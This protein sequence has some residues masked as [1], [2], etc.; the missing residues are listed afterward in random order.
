MTKLIEARLTVPEAAFVVGLPSKTINREIDARIISAS[1]A[2]RR[3]RGSDLFYL[4]AIKDVRNQVGPGLRKSLR[5]AISAAAATGQKEA[6]C[7]HFVFAMDDLRKELLTGFEQ[8]A[9]TTE[10]HIEARREVLSGE[11]VLKGTRIAA[12]HVADLLRR[13][14]TFAQIEED[15]GLS[16]EQVEAASIYDRTHPKRGRPPARRNRRSHVPPAR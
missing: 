6:R 1:G 2:E 13:G 14:A 8:L 11:P 15:Y 7:H 16:A 4:A 3:L 5:R 10:R 12:R 9:R